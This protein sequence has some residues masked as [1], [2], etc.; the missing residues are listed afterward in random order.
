MWKR[1]YDVATIEERCCFLALSCNRLR[2]KSSYFPAGRAD[3]APLSEAVELPCLVAQIGRD[4]DGSTRE[5]KPQ[6]T[7]RFDSSS[8]YTIACQDEYWSKLARSLG[9]DHASAFTSG[10]LEACADG[11]FR[12]DLSVPAEVYRKPEVNEEP[13]YVSPTQFEVIE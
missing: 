2:G 11:E 6:S 3:G 8:Q 12:K 13:R 4:S 10:K 5:L 9:S 1:F 7:I